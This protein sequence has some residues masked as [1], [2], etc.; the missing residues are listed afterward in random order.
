[1]DFELSEHH[2]SIRSTVRDFFEKE[3]KPHARSW[4]E[5]ERFPS[6]IIPRL[7]ELGLLGIRIPEAYGGAEMDTLSYAIVVEE[8]ARIDG[9]LALTLASHNGLGTGHILA[10]GGKAQQ[11]LAHPAAGTVDQDSNR[12][13]HADLNDA[14]G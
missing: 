12:S 4:D 8:A 10:F 3:V 2:A 9:S 7:A 13:G 1:M 11:G 14:D 5:A 6:E